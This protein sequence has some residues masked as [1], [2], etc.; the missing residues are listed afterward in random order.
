M[1]AFEEIVM[2]I[3]IFVVFYFLLCLILSAIISLYLLIIKREPFYE[4]FEQLFFYLFLEILN[5]FNY[6]L[7]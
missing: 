5:P 4:N 2:A 7:W 3:I 6:F 1:E